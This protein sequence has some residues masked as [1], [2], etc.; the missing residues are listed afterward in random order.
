MKKILLAVLAGAA[1]AANAQ[2]A[3][4]KF[5][6]TGTK[7]GNGQT[8]K[9]LYTGYIFWDTQS[10]VFT[11]LQTVAFSKMFYPLDLSDFS[12]AKNLSSFVSTYTYVKA[13]TS[14]VDDA[15]YDYNDFAVAKGENTFLSIGLTLVQMPKKF[16]VIERDFFFEDGQQVIQ[17]LSGSWTFDSADTQKSDPFYGV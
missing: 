6:E 10:G 9:L 14:G 3:I 2:V 12:G 1:L 16:S 13:D 8:G 17:E 11:G 5:A 4:Y 15:G 7:T